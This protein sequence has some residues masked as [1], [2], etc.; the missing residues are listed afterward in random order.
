MEIMN[1]IYGNK[2]SDY[3]NVRCQL[4]N[5]E[6]IK[7]ENIFNI[8]LWQNT[9]NMLAITTNLAIIMVDYKGS[10]VTRH[11]KCSEF[12]DYMRTL[13]H[14]STMCQ[15][16]DSRGGIEAARTNKPYIYL[17]HCNLVDLAI[18]IIVDN[19]YIGALMA[20]QVRL[21]NKDDYLSLEKIV[22]TTN[23]NAHIEQNEILAK[24]YRQIPLIE[25]DQIQNIANL[26]FELCNYN[27]AEALNKNLLQESYK[28][29]LFPEKNDTVDLHQYS[30]QN[31]SSVN[32]MLSM[33][34]IN[35]TIKTPNWNTNDKYTRLLEPAISY[36]NAH[37]DEFVPLS[38]A[39]KICHVS[40]SYF[41]RIF[42][43]GTGV[44]YTSYISRLKIQWSKQLLENTN[45]T[46]SDIS[47]KLGFSSS[48]YFI[49]MFK[50][51]EN[52]TP[53]IYRKYY[54]E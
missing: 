15:K 38:K 43:K 41:S 28:S 8:P 3:A 23:T 30:T 4:M 35:R 31:L 54:K 33:E 13:P 29:I 12:C 52:I 27:I 37:P 10:P 44:T 36:I 42:Y 14:L 51:H 18:P 5:P 17:C 21:T 25:Y 2:K 7:L 40:T 53:N 26:L 45:D 24:Y 50:K 47:N 32:N 46:I 16:C 39:S 20:G 48:S 22:A 9:Q 49:I 6:Y 1:L 34:V 19:K 11:S